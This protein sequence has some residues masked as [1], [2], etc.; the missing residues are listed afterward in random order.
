M[1]IH[2]ESV[3]KAYGGRSVIKDLDLTVEDGE[4]VALVGPSGSGKST[5]L[6]MIAGLT[7]VTGGSIRIAGRDVTALAPQD[8]DVAMVFQSY[9]LYPHMTVRQNIAFGLKTRKVP[10]AEIATRIA[11]A[12][13]QLGLEELLDRRPGQLSGGQRQRVAMGRA[14]VREPS[15]FLLDEP[16]S[17]LDTELRG[18][19][20]TEL[21]QMRD[22][23]RVSSVYV[24]HDQVE[25]MTLGHRVAVLRDGVLQQVGTGT[26]L[27]ENPANRFVAGFIGR[28]PINFV[29][30]VVLRDGG[31][32][33]CGAALPVRCPD[34]GRE[35][36]NRPITV[37]VRPTALEASEQCR[38]REAPRITGRVGLIEDLGSEKI[39]QIQSAHGDGE[40]TLSACL[41]GAVQ[42]WQGE[43]CEL[44]IDPASLYFFDAESGTSLGRNSVS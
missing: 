30:G 12:A 33:V 27:Y 26:D 36:N 44:A 25:A 20:R 15:A 11:R 39:V 6:S 28:V 35:W 42:V 16:L 8:R 14:I 40:V 18:R 43:L 37:A 34:L 9:A 38:D 23:L 32:E 29:D 13:Q 22:R 3:S 21:S 4:W 24:T 7:S 2:L 5:I 10:K 31:V 41:P 19:V 17:N 1:T